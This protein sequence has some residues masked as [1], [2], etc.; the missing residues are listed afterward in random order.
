MFSAHLK[1]QKFKKCI[2]FWQINFN[3]RMKY[4]L[5][6][7]WHWEDNVYSFVSVR[8]YICNVLK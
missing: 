4:L 1:Q 5:N 8:L 2:Y 6:I 7:L 3:Y